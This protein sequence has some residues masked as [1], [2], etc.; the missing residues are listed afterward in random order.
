M[1]Y[2]VYGIKYN[3]YVYYSFTYFVYKQNTKQT[4]T[5]LT[6]CVFIFYIMISD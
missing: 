2:N 5:V 6:L 3:V 4:N 1:L